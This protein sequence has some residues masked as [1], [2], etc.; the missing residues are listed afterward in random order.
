M[1]TENGDIEI[2]LLNPSLA[3]AAASMVSTVEE[4]T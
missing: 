1:K 4:M 2:D 3:F